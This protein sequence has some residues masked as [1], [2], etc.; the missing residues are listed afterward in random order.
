MAAASLS[1]RSP[2]PQEPGSYSRIPA[3]G[4]AFDPFD[5]DADP[6]PRLELTPEQV[7]HC[8]DA[9]A[10]FE[11]K[12][13]RMSDLSEDFESLEATEDNRVATFISTQGPLVKTF[14]DFW[15]MVYQYQYPA[16]VMVTQFDSFKPCAPAGAVPAAV[17]H[18][19]R[20][21]G[22]GSAQRRA[23]GCSAQY[24][25]AGLPTLRASGGR[26]LCTASTGRRHGD[27]CPMR[28][29][30]GGAPT[31]PRH[32]RLAPAPPSIAKS[33]ARRPPHSAPPPNQRPSSRSYD[34]S[35]RAAR[36]TGEGWRRDEVVAGVLHT[37]D[38][39][40]R[41]SSAGTL[42]NVEEGTGP[43]NGSRKA[44]GSHACKESRR[45]SPE[46]QQGEQAGE[47][48]GFTPPGRAADSR[49]GGGS[50]D[51]RRG[52]LEGPRGRLHARRSGSHGVAHLRRQVGEAGIGRGTIGRL[53]RW[54]GGVAAARQGGDGWTSRRRRR[55]GRTGGATATAWLR[56]DQWRR[57]GEGDV[58]GASG[59]SEW[60]VQRDESE[61]EDRL[62]HAPALL[63]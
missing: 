51:S 3:P 45:R 23:S 56:V 5:V 1:R 18:A 52:R 38:G 63:C 40:E 29:W 55:R 59:S 22:G 53:G 27:A 26:H 43:S 2:P 12:R 14:E 24:H 60:G 34:A 36:L 35:R 50:R 28:Q 61:Q 25:P 16:I 49:R 48:E 41:R 30:A 58:A 11:E 17:P 32:R 4:A 47:Q 6:P 21:E 19:R 46:E 7:G 15:E 42:R 44:N 8:S 10:H 54:D 37:R 13:K 57:D 20:W 31:L 62:C 39:G 33:L 9:L